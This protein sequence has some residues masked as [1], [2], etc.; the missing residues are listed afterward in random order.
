M[1]SRVG[2]GLEDLLA[3]TLPAGEVARGVIVFR[4]SYDRIC[5]TE[6][7]PMP[8][9]DRV[10]PE[11]VARGYRLSVA[12][13]KLASFSVRI[14]RAVGLA[15]FFDAIH[16]PDSAGGP[17][18]DP[19]MIEACLAAMAVAR[20]HAVYVGDMPLDID[21]AG[22]AGV[23]VVLLAGGASP[24]EALERTGAPVLGGLRELAASL[25]HRPS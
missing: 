17:K 15:A 20:D 19:A 5:E 23:G 24:R 2:R 25:P 21:A 13:N 9:A 11:L 3:S 4:E 6:T 7:A 22:R 16:G 14:L 10:L 1:T 12:S 18:P 8:D